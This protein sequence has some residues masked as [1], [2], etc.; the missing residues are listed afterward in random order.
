MRPPPRLA[1]MRRQQQLRRDETRLRS[2]QDRDYEEALEADRKRESEARERAETLEAIQLAE[3]AERADA[4]RKE[5]EAQASLASEL[6]R[7]RDRLAVEPATGADSA[8]LRIQLP[9]G[10]KVDR[11]FHKT[12]TVQLVK[13]FVDLHIHDNDL[14]IHSFALATHYPREEFQGDDL[15]KTIDAAHPE[16][17][18]RAQGPSW[19]K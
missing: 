1:D 8:R 15:E 12:D 3:E 14:D 11:R 2:E 10:A 7:K 5:R 18:P 17:F 16:Q 19:G 13:D 6:A 9:N 4:E